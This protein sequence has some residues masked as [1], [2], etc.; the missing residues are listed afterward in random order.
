MKMNYND[1]FLEIF[2]LLLVN[3]KPQCSLVVSKLTYSVD[4]SI[5]VQKIMQLLCFCIKEYISAFN[6][7]NFEIHSH[8]IL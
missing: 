7:Y 4:W 5:F 3:P 1:Y 2:V 8:Q 6:H